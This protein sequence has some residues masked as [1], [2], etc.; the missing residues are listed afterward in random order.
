MRQSDYRG[1]RIAAA[2]ALTIAVLFMVLVDA[3]RDDYEINP[4]VFLPL[5]ATV[6]TLLGLEARDFLAKG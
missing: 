4:L 1:A 6:L 2:A 5:L 3:V